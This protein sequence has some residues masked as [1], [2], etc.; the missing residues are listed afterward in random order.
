MNQAKREKLCV[1]NPLIILIILKMLLVFPSAG[2][3][4]HIDNT[5]L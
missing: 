3:Y 4:V 2:N 1:P 5:S